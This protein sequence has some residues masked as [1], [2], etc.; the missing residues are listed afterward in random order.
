MDWT[1]FKTGLSYII[2]KLGL[3]QQTYINVGKK[4]IYISI[5]ISFFFLIFEFLYVR[6]NILLLLLIFNFI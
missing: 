5:S 1:N 6:L 2:S 3:R 4:S